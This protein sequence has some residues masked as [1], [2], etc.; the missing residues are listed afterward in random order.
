[1]SRDGYLLESFN[2]LISAVLSV[3]A[4]M[5]F[6]AFQKLF[7]VVRYPLSNNILSFCFFEISYD[8]YFEN[9]YGNPPQTPPPAVGIILQDYRRLPLCIIFVSK[10]PLKGL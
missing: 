6:K 7:T 10:P 3:Y 4:L 2:I 9:A 1:M 8:T 5:I